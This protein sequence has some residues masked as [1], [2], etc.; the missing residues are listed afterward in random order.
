MLKHSAQRGCTCPIPRGFQDQ[1]GWCL[2]DAVLA[3]GNPA[4]RMGL[5]TKASLRSLLT[6]TTHDSM[7]L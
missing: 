6:Q 3:G 5:L 2:V 1:V 7:I 4:H